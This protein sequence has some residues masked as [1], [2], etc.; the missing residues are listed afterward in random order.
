MWGE[1]HLNCRESAFPV[2]RIGVAYCLFLFSNKTQ[3]AIS[4][5]F[6]AFIIQQ[7]IYLHPLVTKE[8]FHTLLVH[9][10]HLKTTWRHTGCSNKNST[11]T[12]QE[13]ASHN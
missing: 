3:P 9:K 11:E 12:S 10:N 2:P 8:R 6:I 1:K 13:Q 4:L 5:L 7:S